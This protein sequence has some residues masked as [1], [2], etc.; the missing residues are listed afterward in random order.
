MPQKDWIKELPDGFR[1]YVRRRTKAG[2]L[3]DFSVV[4]IYEDECIVRYDTAH[5]F[6][7]KDVLGK[8]SALIQKESYERLSTWEAFEHAIYDLAENFRRYRRFYE[9]N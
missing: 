2:E 5:G 7:H 4:L 6:A 8:N 9:A 1:I 3:V